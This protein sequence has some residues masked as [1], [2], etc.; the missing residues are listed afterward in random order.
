MQQTMAM[1]KQ[2]TR[3]AGMAREWIARE[4]RI[5]NFTRGSVL[6]PERKLATQIGVS[7]MTLRK[8][9]SSLVE[10]GF[11]ERVHGRGTF[12]SSEIPEQKLQKT[13]GLI[14]P[15]WSAPENLDLVM[16]FSQA[17]EEA[18]WQLKVVHVR[19]WEDRAIPDLL[20]SCDALVLTMIQQ[21]AKVPRN[22]CD[23]LKM[24]PKP[25]AVVCADADWIC[26]D[27]VYY[28]NDERME[29]P[30]DRLY[31]L[32]HRRIFLVDQLICENHKLISIHPSL[33]G[34]GEA[35]R[36]RYPDIEYNTTMMALEIPFF[37]LAHHAI[38]QA[39]HE[40]RREIAGYT[41]VVCPLSFYWAVMAGLRDIG[42]RV[43]EDMSVLTFGDR[44]ES[45]FYCPRPAAFTPELRDHAF[46]TLELVRWRV[47]NPD[48]PP[49]TI[50]A[51]AHF[52]EN[53][54]FAPARR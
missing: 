18:N 7:Y 10:D 3:K 52:A 25:V 24:S 46:R 21:A 49:R 40:H 15:A 27:A 47:Q 43:P 9:V 19:N 5:G 23:L 8:A 48:A 2:R 53:E 35:F 41:A 4:I 13:L 29:E 16:H 39:F 37:R 14:Q 51:A 28:R 1:E 30:C 38:R 50:Q 11:L 33:R 31:E 36:A 44:Q 12:V 17:C 32:G 20:K 22:L 54:T 42:F 45:E 26:R 6:P 34:F